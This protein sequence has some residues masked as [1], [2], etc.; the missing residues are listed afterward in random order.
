[1]PTGVYTSRMRLIGSASIF[2]SLSSS[3]PSENRGV[4]WNWIQS[5]S[6]SHTVRKPGSAE[7]SFHMAPVRGRGVWIWTSEGSFCQPLPSV[8]LITFSFGGM[9]FPNPAQRKCWWREMR[10]LWLSGFHRTCQVKTSYSVLFLTGQKKIQEGLL[11]PWSS[12][13]KR[14]PHSYTLGLAL[15]G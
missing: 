15:G 9:E 13:H 12:S 6:F 3:L 10:P 1:M 5:W 14:S 2:K 11:S 7:L 4:P 8:T